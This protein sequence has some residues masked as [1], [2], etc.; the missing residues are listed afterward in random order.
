MIRLARPAR[1]HERRTLHSAVEA[2]PIRVE[3]GLAV[4]ECRTEILARVAERQGFR[5][6]EPEVAL[7]PPNIAN[8]D[9]APAL[10]SVEAAPSAS[11][12]DTALLAA[13]TTDEP[14][15]AATDREKAVEA[16]L[17]G[18]VD[19]LA[20]ALDAGTLDDVLAVVYVG[21]RSGK[22]RVTAKRA[23]LARSRRIGVSFDVP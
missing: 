9:S 23:I 1:H 12:P 4:V 20:S 7:T 2:A 21:E 6:V 13:D 3:A 22:N 11:P 15:E 18:S 19:D 14:S 17:S 10:P 16:F 8:S 5:R